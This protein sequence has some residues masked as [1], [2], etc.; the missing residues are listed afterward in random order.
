MKESLPK[1]NRLYGPDL[2]KIICMFMIVM[3]HGFLYSVNGAHLQPGLSQSLI[4]Q[5]MT[6]FGGVAVNV[7]I[8]ISGYFLAEQR[9]RLSRLVKLYLEVEFYSLI[10]LLMNKTVM[11]SSLSFKDV[12]TMIF[13]IS[14][15]HFWFI[16]AYFGLSLISP[17]LNIGIRAMN[18]KQ[19]FSA[20]LLLC[21]CFSLWSDLIPKSDPF[22]AGYGYCLTWFVVLYFVA[23]FIRRY[24]DRDTLKTGR[25]LLL[26]A[27]FALLVFLGNRLMSL[28]ANRFTSLKEYDIESFFSRYNCSLVLIA[29]VMLFCAFL[30]MDI[31]GKGSSKAISYVSKLTLGV[32]LIHGGP[33]TSY[34]LWGLVFSLL[35]IEGD[36]LYIAR[37]LLAALLLFAACLCVD[38]I[39]SLIFGLFENRKGFNSFLDSVENSIR[40]T[41]DK[42]CDRFFPDKN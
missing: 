36:S 39:R 20:A 10:I 7:F 18:K 19:H 15:N 17:V 41:I 2:L 42:A 24:V 11:A 12:L 14:F 13:P 22:G 34:P 40:R 21:V 25:S 3:G 16:S 28:I 29:S 23:A 38:C 9:F 26:Y 27:L 33:F 31:K 4:S 37:V 5:L 32:Y 30:S 1:T 8:L 6:T 35:D